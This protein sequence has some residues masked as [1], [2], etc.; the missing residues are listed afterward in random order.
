MSDVRVRFAPSPTG[1]LHVGGARTALY[2]YLFAKHN[3]GKFI[4]RI[5]D[6]DEARSTEESMRMQISDLEWLGLHWDE[7]PDAK[8]LADRGDYGPYRQSRRQKIYQELAVQLLEMG[9]AYYCFMTDEEID[10]QRQAAQ[11]AGRPPQVNS[12]YRDW[13]LEKS[14]DKIA[15]GGKA[16]V[17]FKVNEKRDYVLHDLV[18]GDV[19]FPSDMVGDFVCLR[20]SGMPVYNFCCVIDDAMMKI[21]HVLRA[22]E[23]LSNT[24]RQMMLYEAFDYSLPQFGHMSI[25]LGAD[26][27]K[28]S[29]RHGTTSCNEYRVNGYLPEAM[30][31]FIALLGWSSPEAQEIISIEQLIHQFG[32]ERLNPSPAVFDE[33]KLLW[34]NATH[35]RA[36]PHR[37]LWSRI[38]PFLTEAGL[39]L[40]SEVAWRDRALEAL[41]TSMSKLTDAVELFR[42]LSQTPLVIGTEAKEVLEWP[43]TRTVVSAWRDGIERSESEYLTEQD[44]LKLQDSIKDSQNVKGKHLFQPIRVA[45]IGKPQGTELKMLVPL[46]QKHT[47][48]ERA[49]AVLS[50]LK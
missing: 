8:T 18:R 15:Q 39:T 41:K 42:P 44:F 31:N 48:I 3:G 40:P 49:D 2:N 5:E 50:Q 43:S 32:V 25:I 6:T 14:R 28:L 21:S 17:R 33:Q 36:L 29:K 13:S 11:K 45:V 30:N 46:M 23:H 20:S 1:Y 4:Y 9:K 38:E 7:G 10:V 26:K 27:Q 16:V 22:E 24:L 47:L 34:V 19:T 12:P 35:L 37:E